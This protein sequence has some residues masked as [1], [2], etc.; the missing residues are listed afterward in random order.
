MNSFTVQF[1]KHIFGA[2]RWISVFHIIRNR[3]PKIKSAGSVDSWVMANFLLSFLALVIVV[4]SSSIWL[5]GAIIMWGVIRVIE[6][7]VYQVNVLLFDPYKKMNLQAYALRGYR[8]LLILVIQNYLEIALWFGS[9]YVLFRNYFVDNHG[10][11][12]SAV[13]GFYYSIVTMTT[14]G[15]GEV[16]P[17]SDW[18]RFLV[19]VQVIIG[20]FMVAV[21]VARFISFLPRPNTLDDSE[22]DDNH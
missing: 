8:R 18:T 11:L 20:V 15:Y 9:F 13:G 5:I 22:K 10:V 2:L 7:V 17:S 12:K 14:L 3:F 16:T 19:T 1:W 21:I 6:I 4:N